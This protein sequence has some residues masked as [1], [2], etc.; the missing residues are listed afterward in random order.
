MNFKLFNDHYAVSFKFYIPTR[1]EII[2]KRAHKYLEKYELNGNRNLI[3]AI[4]KQISNKDYAIFSN[5]ENEQEYIQ[6][7]IDEN[8][9]VIDFP[10]SVTDKRSKLLHR[11]DYVIAKNDLRKSQSIFGNSY[12]YDMTK[13]DYGS[14]IDIYCRQNALLAAKIMHEVL[15]EVYSLDPEFEMDIK[16]DTWKKF[17]L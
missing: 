3:E 17:W 12:L 6:C 11:L 1:Q 15:T 9:I 4:V 10:F 5:P 8:G 13:N 16:I 14:A 2:L 7:T